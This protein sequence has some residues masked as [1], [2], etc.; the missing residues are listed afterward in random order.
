M[1]GLYFDE[2]MEHLSKLGLEQAAHD[3]KIDELGRR[4]RHFMIKPFRIAMITTTV[5]ATAEADNNEVAMGE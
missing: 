4:I 2:A 5:N 3:S 1:R